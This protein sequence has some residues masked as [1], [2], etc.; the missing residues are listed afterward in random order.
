MG[1]TIYELAERAGVNASTIRYYERRA[2]L[3]APH[4]LSD[5]QNLYAAA[6]I[7]RVR[8]GRGLRL[9]LDEIRALI[10]M[11]GEGNC[12]EIDVFEQAIRE[13][14]TQLQRF[15]EAMRSVS[16]AM[17]AG[18]IEEAS[19]F[20]RLTDETEGQPAADA[21]DEGDGEATPPSTP[22]PKRK[23]AKS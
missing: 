3:P 19:A 2:V 12:E 23:R 7:A 1:V 14:A 15:C 18:E 6:D 21:V 16:S 9:E 13:R 10:E 4:R 22:N 8:F 20:D 5:G 17:R 11:I